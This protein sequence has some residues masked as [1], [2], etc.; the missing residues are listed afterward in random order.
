MKKIRLLPWT[1][2]LLNVFV[3]IMGFLSHNE[4]TVFLGVF[5]AGLMIIDLIYFKD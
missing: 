3:I 1:I 2:L 5:G 4:Q